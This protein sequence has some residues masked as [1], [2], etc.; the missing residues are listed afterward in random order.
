MP[1]DIIGLGDAGQR[2][3]ERGLSKIIINHLSKGNKEV[4]N[5]IITYHM[6]EIKNISRTIIDIL[7]GSII[8]ART[9]NTCFYDTVKALGYNTTL[10]CVPC[11]KVE[12]SLSCVLGIK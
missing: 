4:M 5:N 6:D 11:K 12:P 7:G 3:G 10:L 2:V 8:G 9:L 1:K